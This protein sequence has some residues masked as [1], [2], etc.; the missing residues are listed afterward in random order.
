V[1]IGIRATQ[2]YVTLVTYGVPC[3]DVRRTEQLEEQIDHTCRGA[4]TQ[5][6]C[7][8]IPLNGSECISGSSGQLEAECSGGS[9]QSSLSRATPGHQNIGSSGCGPKAVVLEA[10]FLKA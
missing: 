1:I 5:T 8:S 9:D 7:S 4:R 3:I 2:W 6:A 10:R